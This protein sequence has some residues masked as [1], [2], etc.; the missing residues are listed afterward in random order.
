[1]LDDPSDVETV[2]EKVIGKRPVVVVDGCSIKCFD[3]TGDRRIH[4]HRGILQESP[5]AT[6]TCDVEHHSVRNY[7]CINSL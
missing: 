1:M 3:D 7:G 2:M 6:W 4:H 5:A